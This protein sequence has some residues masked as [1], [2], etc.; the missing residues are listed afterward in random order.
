[1]GRDKSEAVSGLGK[2]SMSNEKKGI[3][4]GGAGCGGGFGE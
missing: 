2:E 4:G 3:L 1:V